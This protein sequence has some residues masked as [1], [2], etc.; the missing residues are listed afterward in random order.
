MSMIDRLKKYNRLQFCA[1]FQPG[2]RGDFV[3]YSEIPDLTRKY[4]FLECYASSFLYSDNVL[5]YLARNQINGRESVSGYDGPIWATYLFLDLD[6]KDLEKSLLTARETTSFLTERWGLPYESVL[7]SFSGNSG[8]HVMIDTRV[9][10]SVAPSPDLNVI[11][12]TM[13]SQLPKKANV[14]HPETLDQTI[15]DK[16]RIIR[17][18][19]TI[20][21]KLG[22]RKIQLTIPELF[23]LSTEDIKEKAKK[24]QPLYFTDLTGMI[25]TEYVKP[26]P[27]ASE[28]YR[29]ALRRVRERPRQ[30]QRIQLNQPF[31]DSEDPVKR[32]CPAR[33]GLWHN[34]IKE[35]Y[36]HNSAIR[37]VAQFRLLGVNEDRS[38]NLIFF[39]NRE[40]EI[41]LP[42]DELDGIVK[43]VYVAKAPYVYGC[44]FEKLQEFCPYLEDRSKCKH[45]KS[46]LI[47]MSQKRDG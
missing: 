16:Q 29:S 12:A 34:K 44:S 31:P 23:E 46:Q 32:L 37:L 35:E 17:L 19:D 2:F 11:F 47:E 33:Q 25:P 40:N 20:N 30:I 8:Y 24:K 9:F 43:Y 4:E 36:R 13:R 14:T 27:K 38:R 18:P 21:I 5:D 15:G 45:H 39:W 1:K 10:G 28:F 26:N 41:G 7:L 6:S 3:H 42:E 22:L